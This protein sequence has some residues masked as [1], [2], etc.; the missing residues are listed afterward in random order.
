[1]YYGTTPNYL[2]QGITYA[3]SQPNYAYNNRYLS[4]Y[5]TNDFYAYN[6]RN[7]AYQGP[8]SNLNDYYAYYYSNYYN[9]TEY[10]A[11]PSPP[12]VQN[13]EYNYDFLKVAEDT[14]DRVYQL[15]SNSKQGSKKNKK[16][17]K[18]TFWLANKFSDKEKYSVP[19]NN[20][21]HITNYMKNENMK[22]IDNLADDFYSSKENLVKLKTQIQSESYDNEKRFTIPPNNLLQIVTTEETK[23][24]SHI[25]NIRDCEE[26]IETLNKDFDIN[27]SISYNLIKSEKEQDE[28][29][30]L[31]NS[32]VEI[33]E[34]TQLLKLPTKIENLND[35]TQIDENK[36]RNNFVL[37]VPLSQTNNQAFENQPINQLMSPQKKSSISSE[38]GNEVRRIITHQA[39]PVIGSTPTSLERRVNSI[40]FSI[41]T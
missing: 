9:R 10:S 33:R 20:Y 4:P 30:K 17:N 14:E 37:P 34:K 22:K 2:T 6:N 7:P 1:M 13:K 28:E 12:P 3:Y 24:T 23:R 18:S 25:E 11:S 31:S 26:T 41:E 21:E 8:Y 19:I 35:Y 38:E 5:P 36:A 16:K 15:R 32:S 29:T 40:L 27:L 39:E